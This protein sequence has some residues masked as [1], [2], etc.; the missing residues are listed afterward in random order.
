LLAEFSTNDPQAYAV[1]L[2]LMIDAAADP[3]ILG[4]SNHLLYVGR[5]R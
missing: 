3:G 5:K 1:A 4:L 2:R